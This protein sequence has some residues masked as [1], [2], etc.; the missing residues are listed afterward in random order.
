MILIQH[1]DI[2]KEYQNDIT[3]LVAVC[4][5]SVVAMI[6]GV[7][8]LFDSFVDAAVTVGKIDKLESEADKIEENLI[9]RV[10]A[11]GVSDFQKILL[12]DLA[13]HLSAIADRAETV[14]D[15]IRIMV[16]KRSV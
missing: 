9:D 15:R 13:Q 7:E 5:K 16:A 10:F 14:G 8:Q 1:I 12:R 2:P 6:A 4:H 11:G 3:D